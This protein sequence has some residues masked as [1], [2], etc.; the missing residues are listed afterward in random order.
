M[1]DKIVQELK[2]LNAKRKGYVFLKEA[3][4]MSL[5]HQGKLALYKDVFPKIA[6]KY[7]KTSASVERDIRYLLKT[8]GCSLSSKKFIKNVAQNLK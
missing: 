8:S 6:E 5:S 3:I 7:G 4:E 1:E 2:F